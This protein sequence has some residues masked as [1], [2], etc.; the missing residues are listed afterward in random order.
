MQGSKQ[1]YLFIQLLLLGTTTV[2]SVM[3]ISDIPS[4]MAIKWPLLTL[5]WLQTILWLITFVDKHQRRQNYQRLK[6]MNTE[7]IL[8]KQSAEISNQNK[9]EFLSKISH[10]IR[11]P[12]NGILGFTKLLRDNLRNDAEQQQL[13]MINRSA[14]HLLHLIEELLNLSRLEA[15]QVSLHKESIN[16]RQMLDDCIEVLRPMFSQRSV[17]LI[18]IFDKSTSTMIMTDGVSL[19]Q[20]ILNLLTNAI[21]YTPAGQIKFRAELLGDS[22]LIQVSDTGIGMNDKQIAELF[23]P[24]VRHHE[25]DSDESGT[26]LGM[27]ITRHLLDLMSAKINV[28]SAVGEG[29]SI[30]V[31]IP[32]EAVAQV[33][34]VKKVASSIAIV[35]SHQCKLESL[36]QTALPLT[37]EILQFSSYQSNALPEHYDMLM[38]EDRLWHAISNQEKNS[39]KQGNK[40]LIISD[41]ITSSMKQSDSIAFPVSQTILG[42]LLA[43][44]TQFD[45]SL[46]LIEQPVNLKSPVLVVDDNSVNLEFLLCLFNDAGIEAIAAES[47][48]EAINLIRKQIFS[49]IFMDIRMPVMD[50]VE[51]RQRIVKL[52]SNSA[53][54]IV[55][56]TANAM[57]GEAQRY[58]D[59]GFDDYLA[60]PVSR[61]RI[62]SVIRQF[63]RSSGSES[64]GLNWS[65][66]LN[67]AG[68]DEDVAQDILSK[69]LQQLPKLC[70]YLEASKRTTT[71]DTDYIHKAL[72]I[73]S[74][75]GAVQL[76]TL[77]SQIEHIMREEPA[78]YPQE[79]IEATLLEGHLV[80]AQ[81]L[82]LM[83]QSTD[84]ENRKLA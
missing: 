72:G 44:K 74:Y 41:E 17:P 48:F 64:G 73:I 7:L 30:T 21:K 60:K 63:G 43:G 4:P 65:K 34:E 50:G 26:G 83:K 62:M 14:D 53:P 59:L 13:A 29:T 42:R 1:H 57:H 19:R 25:D 45:S 12:L 76:K 84:K 37:K 71:I 33:P 6:N 5:I 2:L 40:L 38:I 61:Q 49:M 78:E 8:A 67:I 80:M 20:I 68:G 75:T 22:L 51:T 66:S 18:P 27:A 46:S 11:T 31:K 58:R 56:L 52:M 35:H 15:G 82:L 10:E 3:A 81:G 79:L 47:G 36:T 24:F 23:E 55:A 39:L 28:K 69:L 32:Y 77:L 54:P 16:C 70:S 9:S